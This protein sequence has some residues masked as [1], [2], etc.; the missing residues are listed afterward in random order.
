MALMDLLQSLIDPQ[1]SQGGGASFGQT[2]GAIAPGQ[3]AAPGGQTSTPLAEVVVQ[4][5]KRMAPPA[6][7]VAPPANPGP[8]Q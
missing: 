3:S 7:S 8:R 1:S 5:K 2:Q 6:Q 4:A